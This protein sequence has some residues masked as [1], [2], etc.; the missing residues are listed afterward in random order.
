M[1]RL[2][3][4][5]SASQCPSVTGDLRARH[6]DGHSIWTRVTASLIQ[7]EGTQPYILTH[8]V[9]LTEER[10]AEAILRSEQQRL[11]EIIEAQRDIAAAEHDL[12]GMLSAL[13]ERVVRLVGDCGVA[14]LL[15]EGDELGVRAIA[16]VIAL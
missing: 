5:V 13:A 7:R 1:P 4:L 16:G 2:M 10:K 11:S 6:R 12:Q 3:I 15:P 8:V 9:D 14:V